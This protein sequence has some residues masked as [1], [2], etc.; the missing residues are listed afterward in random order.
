MVAVAGE[1]DSVQRLKSGLGALLDFVA[2]QPAVWRVMEQGVSD[3]QIV[4][5]HLSQ[6]KRSDKRSRSC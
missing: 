2:E 5:Q 3:P 1:T 4:A 6:R